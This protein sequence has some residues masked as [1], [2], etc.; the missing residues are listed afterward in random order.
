MRRGLHTGKAPRLELLPASDASGG[1]AGE[2]WAWGGLRAAAAVAPAQWA[3]GGCSGH[4]ASGPW[5]WIERSRY[6]KSS[7]YD[8]DQRPCLLP[9]EKDAETV[10]G[11]RTQ[12]CVGTGSREGRELL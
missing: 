5:A 7:T 8:L 3:S 11:A 4:S 6:L 9:D 1:Q 10:P 2:T 12:D